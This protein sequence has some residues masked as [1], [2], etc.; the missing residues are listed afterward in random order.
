MKP[1]AVGGLI[2]FDLEKGE[3]MP[4]IK[5]DHINIRTENLDALIE[6]YG[7]VMGFKPGFRPSF[8]FPGAWLYSGEV[9]AVHLV[10]TPN[11]PVDYDANQRLEHFAFSSSGLADFLAH[12][13]AENVPYYCRVVPDV[14]I[15]QV[16]FFDSDGNHL[17]VDFAAEEE[18][19]LAE[20][21][22]T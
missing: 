8:P 21:K 3:R 7:R 20:F 18:A 12:L 4:E 17:H 2:V 19:D 13:R 14:N 6:F 22:G 11:Q 10:A 5:L 16:N 1:W 15:R 9:A